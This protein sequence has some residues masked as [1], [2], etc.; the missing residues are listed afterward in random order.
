MSIHYKVRCIVLYLLVVLYF[1]VTL[2]YAEITPDKNNIVKDVTEVTDL[3]DSI[4]PVGSKA[5]NFKLKN[6]AGK[7]YDTKDH[8]GKDL[9]LLY[10]WSVFCPYCKESLPKMNIMNEKFQFKGLKVLAVNLDGIAFENAVKTFIKE[11]NIKIAVPLDE[12]AA[13]EFFT[14]ADPFGVNK[15]PTIFIV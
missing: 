5:P 9:T 6:L 14:A 1:S 12:L 3:Y 11:R 13:S 15:T 10:F 8:F 4:I 7:V 2:C